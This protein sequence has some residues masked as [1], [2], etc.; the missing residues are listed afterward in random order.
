M[1]TFEKRKNGW[2]VQIAIKGV[3]DSK[4]FSTKA[5]AQ[6]W[7]SERETIIRQS[8]STGI[9]ADKT[10][11]DTFERY[12]S[13]VSIHK[14][15]HR[16][17]CVR[18]D[19][20][21]N[22]AIGKVRLGKILLKDL[23]PEL[24]GKW[25]DMR[26]DVDRVSGSTVNRE[27]KLLSHVF[28]IASKEWR[29]IAASPTK[30]VRRPKEGKARDR[31]FT[32]DEIDRICL[33]LGFDDQPVKTTSGCVAIA[34]LFAIETG[35]RAGEI[36]GLETDDI[37]GRVATIRKSKNGD[38]RDVPL[39]KRALE[40]LTFLPTDGDNL[41]SVKSASLDAIFRKARD[42]CEIVGATFH[43]SRHLAITRLAR[44]LDVLDLARM[45]GHR[46]V[47]QLMTYFN[48][49]AESIADRLD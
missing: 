9:V 41:F 8:I 39:S 3:R 42:R 29:W 45:V 48:A 49:K 2:R 23:T 26:L 38:E 1:A 19:R 22:D 37:S 13:E 15:G 17:E 28:T 4:V 12:K 14:A 36:V 6:A 27:F 34:F 47:N 5:E 44:K 32:D 11:E 30:D 35:M 16:W 21:A 40:L 33:S 18:L 7:A 20:I 10:I 31:L 43:D 25:R 46:N 24:M